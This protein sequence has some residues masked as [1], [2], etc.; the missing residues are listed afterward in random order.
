MS[1][2]SHKLE[3]LRVDCQLIVRAIVVCAPIPCLP[4]LLLSLLWLVIAMVP[5]GDGQPDAAQL[6]AGMATPPRASGSPGGKSFAAMLAERTETATLRRLQEEQQE[7]SNSVPLLVEALM[8]MV[9]EQCTKAADAEK[10]NAEFT[11]AFVLSDSTKGGQEAGALTDSR[12]VMY[13][14]PTNAEKHCN[15]LFQKMRGEY[16]EFDRSLHQA[17]LAMGG[18]L[19]FS[20]EAANALDRVGSLD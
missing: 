9:R 8:E 7:K 18:K 5:W 6:L 13:R 10:T 15:E 16:S 17:L 4:H 2:L 19:T 20:V 12:R 11:Y 1:G 14:V 3:V